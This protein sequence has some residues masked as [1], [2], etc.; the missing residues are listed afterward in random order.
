[1]KC[2]ICGNETCEWGTEK[3]IITC[4]RCHQDLQERGKMELTRY[5]NILKC[6]HCGETIGLYGVKVD[7]NEWICARCV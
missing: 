4:P 5:A 7:D 3:G 6:N 2:D 1:M